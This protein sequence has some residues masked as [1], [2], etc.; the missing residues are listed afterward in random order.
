MDTI[1]QTGA[2]PQARQTGTVRAR[3]ERR[4]MMWLFIVIIVVAALALLIW[5]GLQIMPQ[6]FPPAFPQGGTALKTV[7]LPQDLPAPVE[8][9]YRKTYGERVPVI[10]SAVISGTARLRLNG[11]PFPG[12]LRFTHDAGQ[13]YRHYIEATFW[14][15]PLMKVNETYL[16]GRGRLELPFG[17]VED[18]PKVNA[19]ANMGLWGE[20]LW[21]P[22]IYITDE[23]VRWEPVDDTTAALIVPF[24]AGEDQRFTVYFDPET[25]LIATMETKRWK[26]AD[27]ESKVRWVLEIYGW[28]EING[29]LLP[30]PAAVTWEDEDSPWLVIYLTDV[31]YNVD[32]SDYIRARGP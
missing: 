5:A 32:V 15:Y 25:D 20:S 16:D 4:P 30:D 12:R 9:F 1:S 24:E 22:A 23:R 6:P 27:S 26:G 29:T 11:L 8:R 14:R 21:L 3:K 31:V 19:G 28:S 17:V 18:E 13:G 10:E 2:Q 7:P